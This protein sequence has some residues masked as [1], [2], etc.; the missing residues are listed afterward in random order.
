MYSSIS[1]SYIPLFSILANS[2]TTGQLLVGGLFSKDISNNWFS[3]IA[4][5]HTVMG[6]LT[7]KENLLKVQFSLPKIHTSPVTLLNYLLMSL[8][9]VRVK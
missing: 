5:S 7:Q 4:L 1:D 9:Q 8:Q 6:N 3:S 2:L